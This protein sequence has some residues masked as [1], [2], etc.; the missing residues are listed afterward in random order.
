MLLVFI[1]FITKTKHTPLVFCVSETKLIKTNEICR[2][3][4]KTK[5]MSLVFKKLK[6]NK[7]TN[8]ILAL[9]TKTKLRY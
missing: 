6:I 8:D 1:C 9:S 3:S 5:L 4:N 7:K 2:L